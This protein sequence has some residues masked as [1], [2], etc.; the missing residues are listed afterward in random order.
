MKRLIFGCILLVCCN[1]VDGTSSPSATTTAI[2]PTPSTAPT[3]ID[4]SIPSNAKECGVPADWTNLDAHLF[5]A[6]QLVVLDWRTKSDDRP[7]VVDEALVWQRG[8]D[9]AGLWW[10]LATLYRHPKEDNVFQLAVVN[11]A[12]IVPEKRFDHPP[13][14]SEVADFLKATTW[15]WRDDS[16]KQ[17]AGRRCTEVWARVIGLPPA[18]ATSRD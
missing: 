3:A 17:S 8:H 14:A 1:H 6:D 11:D 2:I 16:F 9:D 18:S 13:N 10:F 15:G 12:P 4:T 5:H 7:L